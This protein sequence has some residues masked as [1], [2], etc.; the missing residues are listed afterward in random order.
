M[1]VNILSFF[2]ATQLM[3]E[4]SKQ[5]NDTGT[6][7]NN[8]LIIMHI[9]N[10]IRDLAA[11]CFV[12][13]WVKYFQFLSCIG[14]IPK[15]RLLTCNCVGVPGLT[16]NGFGDFI[17][18]K[19]SPQHSKKSLSLHVR[20]NKIITHWLPQGCLIIITIGELPRI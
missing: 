3:F 11:S 9:G 10:K 20:A 8:Y 7:L 4:L 15:G 1:S 17:E 14:Q 2:T 13:A 12:T 6:L 18:V 19:S 16:S 5:I